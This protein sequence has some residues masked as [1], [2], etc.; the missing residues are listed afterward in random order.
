MNIQPDKYAYLNSL[1]HRWDPRY[2]LIA[3]L[4]LIFAFSFVQSLYLLPLMLIATG[5]IYA[6]SGLPV[7]FLLARLKFPGFF[8]LIVSTVLPFMSG[9]TIL[10]N[11]GPLAVKQEG[12][13]DLLLIAIR[14]FCIFTVVIVLFGTTPFLTNIKAMRSLGMP[15]IFADMILFSYRYL[16]EL[17]NKLN[18]MQTSMRLRGFQGKC[19]KNWAAYASLTGTMLVH[20]YEQSERVYSAMILRGY[21]QQDK[22]RRLDEEFIEYSRGFAGTA[23]VILAAALFVMAEMFLRS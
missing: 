1:L 11:L 16:F 23:T 13:L 3:F 21:G 7:S 19:L 10:F 2:K 5:V 8:I 9:K 4:V 14:F 17:G 6:V 18:T 12:C 22:E 15:S 20:A